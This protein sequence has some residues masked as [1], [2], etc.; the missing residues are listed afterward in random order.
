[1]CG[2]VNEVD[3]EITKGNRSNGGAGRRYSYAV[4]RFNGNAYLLIVSLQSSS[5]LG[6]HIIELEHVW[7]L[8]VS[9]AVPIRP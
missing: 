9:P 8:T 5:R 2:R 1:M 7:L 3:R 6:G 4:G